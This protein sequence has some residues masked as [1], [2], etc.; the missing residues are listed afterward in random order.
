MI[1]RLRR[2][3]IPLPGSARISLGGATSSGGISSRPKS[4]VVCAASKSAAILKPAMLGRE[5]IQH[6]YQYAVDTDVLEP[7]K[8]FVNGRTGGLPAVRSRHC[9]AITDPKQLGQLLRDN[10][11]LPRACHYSC[12]V[13]ACSVAFPE[14]WPVTFCSLGGYRS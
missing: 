9:P 8:N 1:R 6:V 13:A 2:E 14:A 7:A 5:T 12:G 4:C 10:P 3:N 11:R